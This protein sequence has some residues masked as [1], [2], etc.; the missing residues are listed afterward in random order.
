MKLLHEG[1]PEPTREAKWSAASSGPGARPRANRGAEDTADDASLEDAL[2]RL[3]AHPE[4]ASKHWIVRQ[5]DHE[6][7][8]GGA[9]RA[10]DGPWQDAPAD[11]AVFRPKLES[12]RGAVV[13]CGMAPRFADASL[14]TDADPYWMALAAVDEAVRNVVCAGADPGRIA[15]LDN[16]CW[17][18][19][20]E[21]EQLGGLVRAAEGCHE[22][23]LAYA[24]PFVS[25][26]DSL[27]NQF[28]DEQGRTI[29]IPP[30]LLITALA[31][32]EDA[33]RACP[34][35]A[36]AEGNALVLLGNTSPA[37]GG[38]HYAEI[39]A[40]AAKEPIPRLDLETGPAAA[41]VA[42]HALADG[43]AL[44]AHDVADGG[45]LVAAAE[46]A[47]SGRLGL[48][49]ELSAIPGSEGLSTEAACFAETPGR[50][51][52]ETAPEQADALVSAARAAG[53]PAA[54]LGQ[55]TADGAL[56]ARH[57]QQTR[58]EVDTQR[59]RAAW[60]E[61]LDW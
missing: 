24:A 26:K 50:Y 36:H 19:C 60:Y 15:L 38:S 49:L 11:A 55:L 22:G 29:R 31:T 39:E 17:P 21:P 30:T 35:A 7:Q 1:M 6:V 10:L 13:G 44:L 9:L 2:L 3:L 16:F 59:L 32:L 34:P 41:R 61:A 46:M 5:Y 28:T 37:L 23:A 33:K 54:P 47:F 4:I 27:H 48:A 42:A 18:S 14:A 20:D 52:L 51:L 56:R 12:E 53:V 58:L 8:G 40:S 25:G 43:T 45:L 57:G